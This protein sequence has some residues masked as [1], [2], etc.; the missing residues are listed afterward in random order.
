ML[1]HPCQD[2]CHIVCYCHTILTS[3][4]SC[5]TTPPLSGLMP[6]CMS[7]SHNPHLPGEAVVLPHPWQIEMLK[8][9]C[10]SLSHAMCG[11][12]LNRLYFVPLAVLDDAFREMLCSVRKSG[13]PRSPHKRDRKPSVPRW[14]DK[15]RQPGALLLLQPPSAFTA[16]GSVCVLFRLHRRCAWIAVS[17]DPHLR[18]VRHGWPHQDYKTPDA[19]AL[20]IIGV[21]KP[22]H[23][24]KVAIPGKVEVGERRKGEWE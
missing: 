1:P 24:N 15:P 5:S 18:P 13:R 10:V 16:V 2:S 9:G 19:I 22:F 4:G 20:R 21:R 23:H 14:H 12:T 8:H 7:L 6:Y 3:K 11:C 17:R